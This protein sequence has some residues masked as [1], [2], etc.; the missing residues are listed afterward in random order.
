MYF[1]TV[2]NYHSQKHY[3]EFTYRFYDVWSQRSAKFYKNRENDFSAHLLLYLV[4]IV[5]MN[6]ITV[7]SH[8]ITITY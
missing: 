4:I 1:V 8:Y 3:S 5:N 6:N 7:N 2:I